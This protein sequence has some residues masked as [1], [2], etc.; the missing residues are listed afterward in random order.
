MKEKRKEKIC[1]SLFFIILLNIFSPLRFNLGHQ[2]G[3][4]CLNNCQKENKSKYVGVCFTGSGVD[5]F[6]FFQLPSTTPFL[7]NCMFF[8]R[9]LHSITAH[10]INLNLNY[11]RLFN[12]ITECLDAATLNGRNNQYV[13][14]KPNLFFCV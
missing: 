6:I 8:S 5:D 7:E 9:L 12:S 4:H 13:T 2:V 1:V 11:T 10:E 14:P 3:N